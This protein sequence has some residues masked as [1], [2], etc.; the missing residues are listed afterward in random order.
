MSCQSVRLLLGTIK[1]NIISIEF[2]NKAL[3][4]FLV[5]EKYVMLDQ[6]QISLFSFVGILFQM[7]SFADSIEE[8]F[9]F[10]VYVY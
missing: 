8:F 4:V 5:V 7:N 2:I 6:I 9:G 1:L 10:W 3:W